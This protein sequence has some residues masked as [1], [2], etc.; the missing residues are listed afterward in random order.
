MDQSKCSSFCQATGPWD[1]QPA[2]ITQS[3]D[4]RQLG[5]IVHLPHIKNFTFTKWY[6]Y[7]IVHL[8]T[9]TFTKLYIYKIVHL[10]HIKFQRTFATL[11]LDAS[12]WAVKPLQIPQ[13]NIYLK[14]S[15]DERL[16]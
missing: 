13:F 1:W 5:K 14:F 2:G 4:R 10:P 6:S 3:G 15:F 9:C 8:Q 7:K 16:Q 11:Q 12:N